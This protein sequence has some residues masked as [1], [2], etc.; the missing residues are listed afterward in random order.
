MGSDGS[1]PA[2][3][4]PRELLDELIEGTT[5]SDDSVVVGPLSEEEIDRRLAAVRSAPKTADCSS[6]RL[7]EEEKEGPH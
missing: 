1:I 5:S 4:L 6:C 3:K 2:G 7:E